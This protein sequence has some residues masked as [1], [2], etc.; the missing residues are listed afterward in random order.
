MIEKIIIFDRLHPRCTGARWRCS[1][2]REGARTCVISSNAAAKRHGVG[3]GTGVD[4]ARRRC[5]GIALVDQRPD[6]YV[7]V[8]RRIAHAVNAEF[9]IDAVCS[10]D[11]FCCVLGARDGAQDVGRRIKAR[12]RE[13]VGP[14]VTCSMGVA[15]NRW[16]A[17]VASAMD[18]PDGLTVLDALPG[19]LLALDLLHDREDDLVVGVLEDEP[20]AAAHRLCVFPRINAVHRHRSLVGDQ[21]SVQEAR[22]GALARAVGPDDAGPALADAQVDGVQHAMGAETMADVGDLDQPS[23]ASCVV[24][25]DISVDE[26]RSGLR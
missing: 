3:I 20:H 8:Q 11:E 2:T 5:P 14:R 26:S 23:H 1:P 21:Q 22:E 24:G 12:L 19:Y 18:K 13:A 17:K 15:P 16:L 4:E 10:V 7:R 25:G 6:L 9:P